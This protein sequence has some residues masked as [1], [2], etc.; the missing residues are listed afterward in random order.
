MTPL[1]RTHIAYQSAYGGESLRARSASETYRRMRRFL[2]HGTDAGPWP[3]SMEL[4]L[5]EVIRPCTREDEEFHTLAELEAMGGDLPEDIVGPEEAVRD[6]HSQRSALVQEAIA[7]FGAPFQEGRERQIGVRYQHRRT[8]AAWRWSF[9]STPDPATCTEILEFAFRHEG[10]PK[11][12]YEAYGSEPPFWPQVGVTLWY[13]FRL[14]EPGRPDLLPFQDDASY[15]QPWPSDSSV[16]L[17]L[18]PNTAILNLR[19]PFEEAGA[20]FARCWSSANEAL[21][22]RLSPGNLR[23]Y[24][25]NARGTAY[26][27]KKLHFEG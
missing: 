22:K 11:L 16:Q 21:G 13:D 27:A 19:F 20:D 15:I 18:G 23:H 4:A 2:D 9:S 8:R 10:L 5:A 25:P 6:G 12:K 1:R 14:T 17:S 7:C 26:V 24:R 3:R